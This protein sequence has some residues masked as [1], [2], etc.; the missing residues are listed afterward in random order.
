MLALFVGGCAAGVIDEQPASTGEEQ[1][2]PVKLPRAGK[3]S[4]FPARPETEM[5]ST[6]PSHP[7]G[8][9]PFFRVAYDESTAAATLNSWSRNEA[10]LQSDGT[11]TIATKKGYP[12]TDPQPADFHGGSFYN[13]GS[14]RYAT[15]T[16]P[17]WTAATAFDTV[18]PSFEALTP[19]GTWIEVHVSAHVVATGEWTKDYSLGVW[20]HD[21][22]TVRRHSVPGQKD[23]MGDVVTDRLELASLADA[24]SVTVTL[25][26]AD[27]TDVSTSPQLR[28]VSAITGLRATAPKPITAPNPSFWNKTLAVPKLS[29]MVY[30]DDSSS[31][32]APTSSSMLL[33]YWGVTATPPKAAQ[34]SSDI[35]AGGP[36]NELF[37]TAFAS[38]A[39]NGGLH[40]IVTRLASFAQVEPLIA[41]GIPVAISLAYDDGELAGAP[42]SHASGHVIVVKGFDAAGQVVVNDPAFASDDT[43]ETTYDRSELSAAWLRAGGTTYVVW[44]EGKKLPVDPARAY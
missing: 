6:T 39:A 38:A 35:V 17:V 43:V 30:P 7:D 42:L 44:P 40:S 37:D 2:E 25:F 32:S 14:F 16:S 15:V 12:G 24:I 4:P 36:G 33:G 10:A 22:S 13:G 8:A 41:H 23:A 31:W 28:A 9:G 11:L 21:S 5:P 1:P 34:L 26:A 27:E 3:G 29:Q 19:A 20:A 18:T